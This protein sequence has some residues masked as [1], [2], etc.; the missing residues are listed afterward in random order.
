VLSLIVRRVLSAIPMLFLLSLVSFLLIRSL[1]GD[2]IDVMLGSAQKEIPASQLTLLRREYG[3]DKSPSSQYWLWLKGWFYQGG[4]AST[5]AASGA[6]GFQQSYD[7]A[8]SGE[9]GD[10]AAQDALGLSYRDGRPVKSVII[11]R[12]PTTLALVGLALIISFTLGTAL[13]AGLACLGL[14]S[15]RDSA[16]SA[17]AARSEAF[18]VT[19]TLA[20]YSA[21][22]FWMAFMAIAAIAS[23]PL[24]SAIPIL[25]LHAPGQAATPLAMLAHL[26]LPGLL[27]AARR[28][29]KIALFIRS[30]A[31]DELGREYVLSA[32]A[33]G[34]SLGQVI[35]RHVLRNCLLPIVNLAGLSLPGLISGSV[36]IE[37]VFCL[38]GMG[39]L[40]FEATLGRNYPVLMGL[41]MLYGAVVVASNLLA[42]IASIALDPRLK[43]AN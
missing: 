4:G 31:I 27:L 5:R 43:E 9:S 19:M 20:V 25:G 6:A 23:S 22:N 15:E 3:L 2:P 24:L 32:L 21:P 17:W 1:P 11:E 16:W 42:D 26:V 38:P 7:L 10:I 13:G 39:R 34:L 37:T 18:A 28:T 30:L 41:F 8:A 14:V 35:L 12:L 29:A 36:L 33:K 40:M